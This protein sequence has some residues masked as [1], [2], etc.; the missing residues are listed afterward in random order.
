MTTKHRRRLRDLSAAE[1]ASLVSRREISPVEVVEASLERIDE[2]NPGLN[3]FTEIYREEARGEA[4]ASERAIRAGEA[5]A[6][7][8]GVPV[9]IKDMTP[10][11]GRRTTLGS[12]VYRDRI[13]EQDAFVVRALRKAGAIIVGKTTTPEFAYSSFTQSPLFGTTRNPWDSTKTSG[14]SSGGSAV[15]VATKC[16]PLA[17]GTDM[18]GSVRIPASLCGIVGLKPSL[19]RIPMDILPSTF[20]NISHFGPLARSCSDAALFVSA[21]QGPDDADIQ[22]VPQAF[23][24][25]GLK[26]I[27]PEKLKLALSLDFGFYR[28][29]PDVRDRMLATVD[30]LRLA[31]VSVEE[32]DLSWTTDIIEIWMD[33]WRVF[34]AA[35]FGDAYDTAA[36]LLDPAVRRLIEQ[37]R[38]ISAVD[39]KLL[40]VRRTQHWNRLR[41]VFEHADALICPTMAL[42]APDAGMDD[43]SFGSI[44]EDGRYNGLDMTAPFNLF[45]QCPALSVPIGFARG[46][47][48]IGLQIV[49]RRYDD[50]GVLQI[51]TLIERLQ[52]PSANL[53]PS[54]LAG[55]PAV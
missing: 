31:G 36:S 44:D 29:D 9:A 21:C 54:N 6:A 14:G 30:R 15:A 12:Q 4:R 53:A 11:K 55:P 38:K 10:I 13:A 8:Q 45:G 51:G 42:P 40:E 35:Y 28:L 3:A 32:V 25:D 37:G 43:R 19:G 39:Y 34:M 23:E 27:F 41:P 52:P 17:E 49:G 2:I 18:G 48:P 20:D 47:L 33:Y 22:S 5:P 26:E 24:M 1:I 16:V 7:L 50:L 46:G